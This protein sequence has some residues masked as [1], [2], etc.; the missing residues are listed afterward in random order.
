MHD[1][2]DWLSTLPPLAVA[3]VVMLII[4]GESMGI[5]LPG[6]IAMVSA[7]LLSVSAGFSPWYIA[8]GAAVGA[9]VGDSIGY[10]IGRRGGR[11]LLIRL[12]RRFPRHLGPPHLARAE[13]VFATWGV[14]A[15]FFG[16]FVAL[17]RILAGPLAGALH[18]PYGKFL[19]ANAAGGLLWAFGTV[20]LIVWIGEAAE[21]YLQD[22]AWAALLS[23]LIITLATTAW[24]RHR[25]EREPA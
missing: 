10:A 25:T 4:G 24:I 8:V 23:G 14:W 7:A 5:P 12:G 11:P 15:V 17:L 1:L 22:F 3:A 13:S 19:V 20:F 2:V 9:I 18:V 6:E 16:R 21:R